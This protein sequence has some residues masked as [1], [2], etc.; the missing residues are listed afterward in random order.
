MS[1]I[2]ASLISKSGGQYGALQFDGFRVVCD[3]TAL[4]TKVRG[5]PRVDDPKVLNRIFW[6]LP[7]G[8]P[9]ADIPARD[10]P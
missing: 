9:W 8:G 5:V 7:T 3:T 10:G 1:V 4:G 6:R 2:S